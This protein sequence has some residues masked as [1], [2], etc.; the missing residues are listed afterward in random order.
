MSTLNSV[1]PSADE[2]ITQSD[3]VAAGQADLAGAEL[4]LITKLDEPSLMSKRL[5]LNDDGSLNSDG[6]KCWMSKGIAAR[7]LAA[8]AAMLARIIVACRSNQ[9]IA[10]GSMAKNIAAPVHIVTKDRINENPG[11]IARTRDFINYRSGVPSWVLIDFDTKGMPP[12]V[13]VKIDASGG[14]WE[15]LLKIAPGLARAARVSRSSTSAGLSRGDTG[16]LIPGSDGEHHY[17][18]VADGGDIERFRAQG[19]ELP[20]HLHEIESFAV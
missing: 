6:S 8:T 7:A 11:C 20:T 9:A 14:M 15:C 2:D 17:L 3:D 5:S 1:P 4:T 18:L 19:R 12:E 10:L 16:E 13:K